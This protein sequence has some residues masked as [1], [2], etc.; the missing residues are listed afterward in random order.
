MKELKLD[1]VAKPNAIGYEVEFVFADK[2]YFASI[3]EFAYEDATECMIFE[4]WPSNKSVNW[5]DLWCARYIPVTEEEL[6]HQVRLFCI[7][8]LMKE[9]AESKDKFIECEFIKE[10]PSLWNKENIKK[11]DPTNEGYMLQGIFKEDS[12]KLPKKESG[13]KVELRVERSEDTSMYTFHE[14]WEIWVHGK[15]RVQLVDPMS[16]ECDMFLR[17]FKAY[18][19]AL[20]FSSDEVLK[21]LGIKYELFPDGIRFDYKD[22]HYLVMIDG[23]RLKIYRLNKLE[24]LWDLP[25]EDDG[26]EDDLEDVV[27][28]IINHV[29]L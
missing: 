23:N 10:I 13:M 21:N 29:F 7:T 4:G 18:Y 16:E 20:D 26:V 8:E 19:A 9:I 12:Q 5:G 24:L 27:S 11:L 15:C 28:A 22:Q 1:V 6:K 3:V 2:K 17:I 25:Y 14:V